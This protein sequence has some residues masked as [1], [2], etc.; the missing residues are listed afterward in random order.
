M[1]IN[2]APIRKIHKELYNLTINNKVYD[3][4]LLKFAMKVANRVKK[5][6]N[7]DN[8][9]VL[10]VQ[11]YDKNKINSSSKKLINHYI[12]H[13][14]EEKKTK[15]IEDYITASRRDGKW[16]YLA[17]SH[18]DSAKDHKPYQGKLYYDENAPEEV[19]SGIKNQRRLKSIQ[20]VMGDP[21]WFITRPNC[22]HYF[23]SMTV[24]EAMNSNT[25]HLQKRY[26]THTK[27]GNRAFATP[28]TVAIEE[29]ED[30]L[31]L[32][33]TLYRENPN[34]YLKKLIQKTEMLL[35]KWKNRKKD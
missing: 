33:K 8:L 14:A 18:E 34:E 35:K 9:P 20:W 23:V 12:T 26:N 28:R 17:R 22:R 25:K 16:I 21:V 29:Y 24:F 7:N 32:L 11:F 10:I 1:A 19:I 13:E 2:N 5:L 3:T 4:K 31:K 30:R 6:P 27:E 15:I